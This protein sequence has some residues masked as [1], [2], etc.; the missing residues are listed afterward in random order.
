MEELERRIRDRAYAIWERE[1]RPKG[2]DRQHWEQATRELDAERDPGWDAARDPAHDPAR[3]VEAPSE[4]PP[5]VSGGAGAAAPSAGMPPREAVGDSARKVVP[6]SGKRA[7]AERASGSS[8]KK[9][10]TGDTGS[11]A[12]KPGR[13]R[14]EKS[15]E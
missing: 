14:K 1:G 6:A 5:G 4:A 15:Q 8:A 11:D 3:Q 2:K 13:S 12:K 9:S 10:A 7:A